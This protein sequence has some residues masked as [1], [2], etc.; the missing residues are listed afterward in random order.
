MPL[1]DDPRLRRRLIALA[2]V[3]LLLLALSAAWRWSPLAVYVTPERLI[4]ALHDIGEAVGPAGAVLLLTLAL[5]V[6]IPLG[7]M[8]LVAQLA[9]GPW[10]GSACLLA[11]A[12]L[13]TQISQTLGR[14]LGQELLERL[15]GP[16]LRQV[17]QSMEQ[18][19]LVAVI[20]LRLVPALPFAVVNMIAGSTRLT[21]R[22]M[23]L[24]SLL[25][26]LP[27]TVL[28]AVFTDHIVDALQNPGPGR[29][30]L[31]GLIVALLVG[32]SWALKRWLAAHSR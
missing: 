19:G 14:H 11:G 20:A 15:A 22:D 9:L 3:L 5:T 17:S 27:G 26:M 8:T 16:K 21:R 23:L 28:I 4:D 2:L 12:L 10:M 29:W 18:R 24:G 32:G 30:L 31:L 25:G 13:S 7:L 1:L 6:A